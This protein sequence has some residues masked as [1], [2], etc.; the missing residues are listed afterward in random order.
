MNH[1]SYGRALLFCGDDGDDDDVICAAAERAG[2]LSD[3]VGALR[4]KLSVLVN[5]LSYRK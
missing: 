1:L 3:Q 5:P 4:S 2:E